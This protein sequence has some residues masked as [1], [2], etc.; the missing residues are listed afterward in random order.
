MINYTERIALLMQ[1]VVSRVPAL[2]FIDL[3]EVLVFAR[4]GRSRCRGRVRHLPLPDAAGERAGLLLL[5]RSRHGRADAALGVV[6]HQ[7]AGVTHRH[8]RQIKYLI[9]FMLPRFCDQIARRVRARRILSAA[10]SRGSRSSTRSC[11]SCITSIR[12]AGRHPRA[13]SAPTARYSAALPRSTVLRGGRGDGARLPR[14]PIPIPALYEFLQ[15]DF[16]AL[17]G[18]LRRRRR[19]DASATSRRSRSATSRRSDIAGVGSAGVKVEPLKRAAQPL[20][21]HRRRSAHPPVHADSARA[22]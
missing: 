8:A 17:D 1:D 4:F 21:L 10:P 13:S 7:V 3:S 19:H 2:S 12:T 15:H 6:R 11:T 16:E 18:T 9:S 14:E 20:A 22:G 5:A